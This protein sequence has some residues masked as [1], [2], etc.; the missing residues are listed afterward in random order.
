MIF[1]SS[2]ATWDDFAHTAL[3][4][5]LVFWEVNYVAV[6]QNLPSISHPHHSYLTKLNGLCV[7]SIKREGRKEGKKGGREGR[8]KEGREG[9]SHCDSVEMNLI[10]IHEEAGLIPGLAQ[11]VK[12]PALT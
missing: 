2:E 12:D 7:F 9:T 11:W 3:S 6:D 10:S 4:R 1:L 8:W 5:C